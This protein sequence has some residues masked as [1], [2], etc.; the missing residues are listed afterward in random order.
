MQATLQRL[1][2][3]IEES[4]IRHVL[5]FLKTNYNIVPDEEPFYEWP[6]L[7][8]VNPRGISGFCE[9]ARHYESILKN[10]KAKFIYYK[11]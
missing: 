11:K 7:Y 8:N 5:E 9:F 3:P 4:A 10:K 1:T 6:G 2:V